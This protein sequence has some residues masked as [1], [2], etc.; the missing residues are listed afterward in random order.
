MAIRKYKYTNK[1]KSVQVMADAGKVEYNWL[2]TAGDLVSSIPVVGD[3]LGGVLDTA[4]NLLS[5]NKEKET[6]RANDAKSKRAYEGNR[7]QFRNNYAP[8]YLAQVG[9][10]V[11]KSDVELEKKEPVII[12]NENG[13]IEPPNSKGTTVMPDMQIA[14]FDG[15]P[16]GKEGG[17]QTQLPVE[18]KVLSDDR[19][20]MY[21]EHKGKTYASVANKITN[22]V[23]R[24]Q[25]AY[26]NNHSNENKNSLDITSE[27]AQNEIQSLFELQELEKQV[28]GQVAQTEE[29]KKGG[30]L[31]MRFK[32]G[33]LHKKQD[34][35][36]SDKLIDGSVFNNG[37][38]WGWGNP[39]IDMAASTYGG[40]SNIGTDS[41][42]LSHNAEGRSI[43]IYR[44]RDKAY[45]ESYTGEAP[46][47][48]VSNDG[49]QWAF[50]NSGKN[51]PMFPYGGY[52]KT[53][54]NYKLNYMFP[55]K[56][57]KDGGCLGCGGKTMQGGGKTEWP[58]DDNAYYFDN[59]D[60][61]DAN[62]GN[63]ST[64][65]STP[66]NNPPDNNPL[67]SNYN[68]Q[69]YSPDENT[70]WD[71]QY[72]ALEQ[73]GRAGDWNNYPRM[74][75]KGVSPTMNINTGQDYLDNLDA[76]KETIDPDTGQ[77]KSD[78][79]F[80]WQKSLSGIGKYIAPIYNLATGLTGADTE[81]PT[82]Y[83]PR[84]KYTPQYKSYASVLRRIAPQY[85]TS[86]VD[87]YTKYMRANNLAKG[88]SEGMGSIDEYNAQQY[89]KYQM[90]ASQKEGVMR[91]ADKY[92]KQYNAMSAA[93]QRE[94]FGKSA[95]QFGSAAQ[96]G[97]LNKNQKAN[98][99]M[100]MQLLGKLYSD[101]DYIVDKDGNISLKYKVNNKDVPPEEI[102]RR[103]NEYWK[104]NS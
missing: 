25:K 51:V 43:P 4:G 23:K 1:K 40:Y 15:N 24:V 86:N 16:H 59:Q 101:V 13:Y 67:R 62:Q 66:D 87:P 3:I 78:E 104:S 30:K 98:D 83:Y 65:T 20:I 55:K 99:K 102:E 26:D 74:P 11:P 22:H 76:G 96:M 42:Y 28:E 14:Q 45:D 6:Q 88:I 32:H 103:W 60:Y 41:Q 85:G 80:D 82:K 44:P 31:A 39:N 53:P 36:Y 49:Q 21:G 91:E 84:T 72:G 90:D 33:D 61:F 29:M 35:G 92:A 10:Q 37:Q 75:R 18:S 71:Q 58:I 34:G 73:K 12:D 77:P 17:I 95:E 64:P 27:R 57:Y 54:A 79:K 38:N 5:Q 9:G 100:K 7:P 2:N 48:G 8:T 19:K 93:K 81:D 70:P 89:D 94:F 97:E 50:L 69:N 52:V 63:Y 47:V 46:K 56:A 68:D